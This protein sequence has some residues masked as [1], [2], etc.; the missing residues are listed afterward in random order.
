MQLIIVMQE[1]ND[2]RGISNA[3]RRKTVTKKKAD[4]LKDLIEREKEEAEERRHRYEEQKVREML[5]QHIL[6]TLAQ[7]LNK[8]QTELSF[9]SSTEALRLLSA[10]LV[11]HLTQQK[12]A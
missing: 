2:E 3:K 4:F 1:E 9:K 6:H 11:Q 7:L 12:P 10:V 5:L 8:V